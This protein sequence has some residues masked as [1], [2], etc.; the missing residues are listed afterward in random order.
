MMYSLSCGLHRHSVLLTSASAAFIAEARKNAAITPPF[1]AT[2]ISKCSLAPCNRR[3]GSIL[4]AWLRDCSLR[5]RRKLFS[6]YSEMGHNLL[7]EKSRERSLGKCCSIAYSLMSICRSPCEGGAR[8][9]RLDKTTRMIALNASGVN[10]F[11]SIFQGMR[12]A[13]SNATPK[14]PRTARNRAVRLEKSACCPPPSWKGMR[15][16]TANE[17]SEKG[18]DYVD[19]AAGARLRSDVTPTI[20]PN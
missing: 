12:V 5:T 13:K 2:D 3:S 15:A 10:T 6:V 1:G 16:R 8:D 20:R 17:Y 4:Y 7:S 18:A 19:P 11:E 9:E 14:S